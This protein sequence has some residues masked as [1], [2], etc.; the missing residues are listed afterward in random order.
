M[1]ATIVDRGLLEWVTRG[2]TLMG[3]A[4]EDVP[5]SHLCVIRVLLIR[6][7]KCVFNGVASLQ[8]LGV[9]ASSS[10]SFIRLFPP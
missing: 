9:V 8:G 3:L 2:T 1:R 4:L 6:Q 5:S 7:P 10:P